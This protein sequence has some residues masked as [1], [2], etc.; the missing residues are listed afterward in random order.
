M[1]YTEFVKSFAE[2]SLQELYGIMF[3]RQEVFVVE[4]NA[5]YLDCDGL[6][7]DATH[8]FIKDKDQIIAY[9]R[10]IPKG[11]KYDEVSLGR[12]VVHPA[13]RGDGLGHRLLRL[14]LP[15]QQKVFMSTANRI[16]AQT[17]LVPFYSLYG[18]KVVS[19]EY[20][21]DGIPHFEMFKT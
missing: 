16:S 21:E 8:F 17:Y 18:F 3:L 1:N 14:A 7:F 4:Q 5:A 15:Y 11:L 9:C 2:L 6:D 12:V 13:Y 20:L 10:L 19:E